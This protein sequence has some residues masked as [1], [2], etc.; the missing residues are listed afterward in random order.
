M[1][2]VCLKLENNI[3]KNSNVILKAINS[4]VE[5][6]YGEI[7]LLKQFRKEHRKIFEYF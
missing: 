2:C 3:F 7:Y 6:I 1:E 5:N 4:I